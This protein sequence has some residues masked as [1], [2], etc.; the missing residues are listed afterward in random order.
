MQLTEDFLN[1][2]RLEGDDKADLLIQTLWASNKSSLLYDALNTDDAILSQIGTKN[3]V[4]SFILEARQKPTW[5]DLDKIQSGQ[6]VFKKY[7]LDIMTLLG[8]LSLPYC[9]AASPGNKALALT[10]KMRKSTGKRLVETA[11]FIIKVLIPGSLAEGGFGHLQINKIRLVHALARYYVGKA[12][13]DKAWGV[14]INQEDMAGTNLAFSYMILVGLARTGFKLEQKEEDDFLYVWRYIGFQM[15]IDDKLLPTS[16]LEA[17][18]IESKIRQRHFK[19]SE[20]G[21]TLTAELIQHYKQYFPAVPAYFVDAQIR[22]LIGSQIS[23]FLGLQKEPFKDEI[24]KSLN[25]VQESLNQFYT[26]KNAYR[27]MLANHEV[28][29]KRFN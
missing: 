5:F 14:P 18:K 11:D 15:H 13:W 4:T 3:E 2:K 1:S 23:D 12:N 24:L 21:A 9:Y 8:A 7:A 27:T 26:N 6:Q 20:E 25:M 22:Y 29:K 28:L 16:K 17:S 10:Q 19:Y